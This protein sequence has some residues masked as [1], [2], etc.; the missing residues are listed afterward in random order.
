MSR[1][2]QEINRKIEAQSTFYSKVNLLLLSASCPL[3]LPLVLHSTFKAASL[4]LT[5]SNII[6]TVNIRHYSYSSEL[7]VRS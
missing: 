3:T 7:S 4:E 5:T 1:F 2:V 6:I